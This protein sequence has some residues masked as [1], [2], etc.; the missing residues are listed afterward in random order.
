MH[1]R[2]EENAGYAK[3]VVW[4][5]QRPQDAPRAERREGA[6]E[7]VR[8]LRVDARSAAALGAC[9][10][11]KIASA[12]DENAVEALELA[13]AAR[14]GAYT[15]SLDIP[16]EDES[17]FCT[18]S[19][20]GEEIGCFAVPYRGNIDAFGRITPLAKT[21][22]PDDLRALDEIHAKNGL[23]AYYDERMQTRALYRFE[24]PVVIRQEGECILS[25]RC[26]SAH[27]NLSMMTYTGRGFT[28]RAAALLRGIDRYANDA[29]FPALPLV[30]LWGWMSMVS[31]EHPGDRV[32]PPDRLLRRSVEESFAWGANNLEFLPV[33]ADGVALDILQA[34]PKDALPNYR[35]SKDPVWTA[36]RVTDV[37]RAAHAHGMV[38][39]FFLYCLHGAAFIANAMDAQERVRLL[40]AIAR[41]YGQISDRDEI[42]DAFDGV[43]TEAWFP[44]DAKAYM[45]ALWGSQPGAFLLVSVNDG[46]QYDVVNAGYSPAA[47]H[48]NAHWPAFDAQHTGYDHAY[49]ILPYPD[50]FY[51]KK[52]GQ[53][54]TYM[55]GCGQTAHPRKAFPRIEPDLP[56]GITNRTVYE[57]WILAQAQSF[58]LHKLMSPRSDLAMAMCWEAD[59]ETMCPPDARRYVY[60]ASQD[61]LRLAAAG[62]LGDTGSG[63]ELALKRATRLVNREDTTR[64]RPR[65]PYPASTLFLQNRFIQL[66]LLPDRSYTAL[67]CDASQ[68]ARFYCS[69]ACTWLAMPCVA[70]RFRDCRFLRK[71]QR[72]VEAAGVLARVEEIS[73]MGSGYTQ[74]KER[75]VYTML[76]ET[77][78]LHTDIYREIATGHSERVDTFLGFQAH[79]LADGCA[80]ERALGLNMPITLSDAAGA[81]PDVTL[82]ITSSHEAD[83][84]F[85]PGKGVCVTQTLSGRHDVHIDMLVKTDAFAAFAPDALAA[86]YETLQPVVRAQR[87]TRIENKS[88]TPLTQAVRVTNPCHGPYFV[89]ENGWWHQRGATPCMQYP[90]CDYVKLYVSPKDASVLSPY[91][92]IRDA[93]RAGYGCQ[94]MLSFRSI[95]QSESAVRFE[96]FVH[97]AN[98]MIYAPRV[99][100]PQ[101][102]E[103]AYIGDAPWQYFAGHTLLLPSAPQKC[104]RVTVILG[105]PRLPCVLRT[106]AA[107]A[108]AR[109]EGDAL[110]LETAHPPW[111]SPDVPFDA[112]GYTAD[113]AKR[114]HT[115][116]ALQGCQRIDEDADRLTVRLLAP[117]A[118]I[119]FA[120]E[121]KEEREGGADENA[122]GSRRAGENQ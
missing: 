117:Y 22:R 1:H 67:Y 15:L 106:Y 19:L 64:I 10:P 33:N 34:V 5:V 88:D 48:Y 76:T 42:S 50:A 61:P 57:D 103:R 29:E 11:E 47:H 28:L 115:P 21:K 32:T 53:V 81:L 25:L 38:A 26:R 52:W 82:Y 79:T 93:L 86:L 43:I 66:L 110:V 12:A 96:A 54:Y 17:N 119:R 122:R 24:L 91:G 30:S 98:P 99:D 90:D 105:K 72:I 58:A 3:P 89:R 102:I 46:S 104:H 23:D 39:E 87:E 113:I 45:R 108:G 55:Q 80:Q 59:E 68:T 100:F 107:M 36:A 112:C 101:A 62:R 97:S 109:F 121:Q 94:Y 114:G 84:R 14:P 120:S 60:A 9:L 49:P 83:V 75:A 40:G 2:I 95:E 56:F 71:Q 116:I 27:L 13:F 41:Q 37:L 18:V 4:R 118:C 6:V 85:L 78:L 20:N 92:Y 73:D 31:F 8:R 65:H 44:V 69:G 111:V 7:V 70:T 16:E 77:P 35:E 51:H 63:G 74:I